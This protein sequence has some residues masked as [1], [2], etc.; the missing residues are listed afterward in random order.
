MSGQLTAAGWWSD[1]R[2]SGGVLIDEASVSFYDGRQFRMFVEFDLLPGAELWVKHTITRNF[3]LHDQRISIESGAI[4]W[5]ANAAM[6]SSPGPWTLQTMRRRNQMTDQKTPFFT[7]GSTIET[8]AAGA[9]TGGIV[10]D[11]M[12]I[13]AGQG[14]GS[15]SVVQNAGLRGLAPGAYHARLQNTSAQNAVGVYDW[16]WEERL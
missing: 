8:G 1:P 9:A 14:A 6:A 4:R 16:W 5:T 12:R 15:A 11:C 2:S 10:V 7:S 3:I 13:A